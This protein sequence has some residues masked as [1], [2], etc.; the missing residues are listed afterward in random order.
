LL[1]PINQADPAFVS[2]CFGGLQSNVGISFSIYG[3]IF[4]KS[5]FVVFDGG[6]T[7]L[8]VAPKNL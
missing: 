4:L 8:G 1:A 7:R 3:D 6:N 2:A 5:Q